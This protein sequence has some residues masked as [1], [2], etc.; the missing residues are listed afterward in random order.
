MDDLQILGLME[1]FKNLD[2]T[3]ALVDIPT[4]SKPKY[5]Q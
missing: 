2:I 5:L 4:Y 3:I 1:K